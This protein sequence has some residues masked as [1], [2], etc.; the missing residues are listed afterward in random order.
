M[1][2]LIQQHPSL[3]NHILWRISRW[4]IPVLCLYLYKVRLLPQEGDLSNLIVTII[5]LFLVLPDI[6]SRAV[7]KN[8]YNP[9][10]IILIC[11][12]ILIVVL[13]LVA[14]SGYW[15]VF[16][17]L[18]VLSIDIFNWHFLLI[19]TGIGIGTN[20]SFFFLEGL[21][22]S[23]MMFG[24]SILLV[25]GLVSVR[26]SNHLKSMRLQNMAMQTK[27]D[28]RSDHYLMR[29]HEIRTPLTLIQASVELLLDGVPG[30]LT[31]KQNEFLVDIEEN[32][33]YIKVLME[34]MLTRGK[35]ESG[36]FEPVF[37]TIDMRDIILPVVAD[38]GTLAERRKQEIRV[39]HPQILP[40]IQG[41]SILLRQCFT[42][43]VLNAIRHTSDESRIVITISVNDLYLTIAITDDGAGM[44]PERRR[45]LFQRFST[46]GKGTGLG[47][48]ITKQCVELHGGKIYV[49]TS[50]GRGT[51]FLLAFPF[52]VNLGGE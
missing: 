4:I 7:W 12:T 18:I 8:K 33:H 27:L 29:A 46:D 42:N 28:T 37:E 35:L 19:V 22:F 41:D 13:C 25:T 21:S 43:L 32:S 24:N 39:Y 31:D 47:L 2:Q 40:N 44:S 6:L 38:I 9:A 16:F 45:Q 11:D 49:D 15:L 3:A 34:N 51:T 20:T 50:L 52:D 26:L 30:P 23:N 10:M 36:V 1:N 5:F 17:L 48:L 14:N